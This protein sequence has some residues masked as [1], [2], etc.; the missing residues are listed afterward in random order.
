MRDASR[1]ALNGRYWLSI[2]LASV[3]GANLGDFVSHDLGLG[4]AHGLPFLA[5]VFAAILIAE[6]RRASTVFYWLAI[7]TLRTAAT[8]LADL[9]THD[10]RL[11]Y[12]P[13]VACLAALLALVTASSRGTAGSTSGLPPLDARYWWAM[14]LAGTLGTAAGDAVADEGGIGLILSALFFAAPLAATLYVRSHVPSYRT[15]PTYWLAIVLIRS[16]GTNLGDLAAH[17]TGLP[18]STALTA[19][20]LTASLLPWPTPR[21]RSI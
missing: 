12:R 7:V 10:L 15:K 14:L 18:T 11:G 21:P 13:V 1:P 3:F 2:C 20:I 6:R 8:N 16:A 4:H 5:A 19:L 17:N 9:A